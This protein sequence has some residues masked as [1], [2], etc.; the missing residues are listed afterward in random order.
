MIMAEVVRKPRSP[1]DHRAT[2]ALRCGVI[3]FCGRALTVLALC[4]AIGLHWI[5]LQSVAWTSM[6][7]SNARHGSLCEAVVRT[8]DGAHP[9]KLCHIVARGKKSEK[10][11]EALP[12]VARLHLICTTRVVTLLP[13]AAPYG[14]PRT[15]FSFSER[16]LAPPVPPPRSFPG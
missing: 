8:F 9:C 7:V 14:Y 3:F 11:S 12:A 4:L 5:A 6:L 13:P 10:K 15:S 2:P 1:F 16:G